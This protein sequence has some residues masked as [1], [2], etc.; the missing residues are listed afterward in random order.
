LD[1]EIALSRSL[2]HAVGVQPKHAGNSVTLV[3]HGKRSRRDAVTPVF[4]VG[5][6]Q[7]A[8]SHADGNVHRAGTTF[9][10]GDDG[11]APGGDHVGRLVVSSVAD[12]MRSRLRLAQGGHRPI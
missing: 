5:V 12:E 3:F 1:F 9:C 4:S 11:T 10:T 8:A 7:L 2:V 6:V